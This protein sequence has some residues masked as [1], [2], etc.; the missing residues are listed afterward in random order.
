MAENAF[1]IMTDNALAG[2]NTWIRFAAASTSN[3]KNR[4]L[5]RFS[6]TLFRNTANTMGRTIRRA[7][8]G[9]IK[10]KSGSTVGT[11]S[12]FFPSTTFA[13]CSA[14]TRNTS[15]ADCLKLKV[16]PHRRISRCTI[17][18]CAIEPHD[19]PALRME[20]CHCTHA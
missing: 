9:S 6:K 18:E 16:K 13:N 2:R 11:R 10:W 7:K 4:S 20:R 1:P 19:H 3:P 17:T 8:A 14:S 12:G 5:Q 15:D